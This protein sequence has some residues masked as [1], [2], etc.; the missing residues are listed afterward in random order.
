MNSALKLYEISNAF[1]SL[2]QLGDSDDLP[3]E[4]IADTLEALEG[5]FEAKAVQVAKFVLALEANAEA[6]RLGA[7]QMM[8]R[9][10]RIANRAASIKAYLQF[11]LQAMDKKRIESPELVIS[12]RANPPAVVITDEH[13]I[14]AQF[15]IQPEPPP[16]RIDKKAIKAAIDA[17]ERVE[18]AY[19]E[20]GERLEIKP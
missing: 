8:A 20:A 12:R 19:V 14:P 15:W 9:S 18:G 17:G 4:V 1:Q 6:I 7:T 10:N 2:E 3:D 11:H 13:S 5:D 16:K